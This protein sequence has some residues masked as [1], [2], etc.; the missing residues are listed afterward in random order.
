MKLAPYHCEKPD[1][2]GVRA[3]LLGRERFITSV[4]NL[5][6]ALATV[7]AGAWGK[8]RAPKAWLAQGLTAWMGADKVL[9]RGRG[10]RWRVTDQRSPQEDRIAHNVPIVVDS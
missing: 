5:R 6:E 7:C 10:S 4:G 3:L 8:K 9:V 1:H 2:D